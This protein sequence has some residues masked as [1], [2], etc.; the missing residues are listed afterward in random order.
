[1][2]AQ[3][4]SIL[5]VSVQ[6]REREGRENWRSEIEKADRGKHRRG[7]RGAK[8]KVMTVRQRVVKLLQKIR[9]RSGERGCP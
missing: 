5:L 9:D 7:E 6:V 8:E 4:K 3:D 2:A 1:L